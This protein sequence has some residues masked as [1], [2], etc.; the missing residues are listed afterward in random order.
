V[1]VLVRENSSEELGS[2]NVLRVP[3]VSHRHGGLP[4]AATR[5]FFSGFGEHDDW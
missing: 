4:P 2:A 5:D 1:E 3:G